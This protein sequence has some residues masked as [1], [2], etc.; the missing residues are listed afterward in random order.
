[1]VKSLGIIC[2]CAL[3]GWLAKRWEPRQLASGE[4]A[5]QGGATEAM[6]RENQRRF[7]EQIILAP[8]RKPRVEE[9]TV[10]QT[11]HGSATGFTVNVAS[12]GEA[13]EILSVK[14]LSP[15]RVG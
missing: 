11:G 7:L 15:V 2:W 9:H 3:L 4:A 5:F 10:F 1:M 14:F 6:V 12:E 13:L 8:P